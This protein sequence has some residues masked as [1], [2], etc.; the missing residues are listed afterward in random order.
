MKTDWLKCNES[1]KTLVH[2]AVFVKKDETDP[3]IYHAVDVNHINWW[4]NE[5]SEYT[6]TSG[7]VDI[8][9]EWIK[10]K[11]FN[12]IFP[13]NFKFPDNTA[14]VETVARLF[15][16]HRKDFQG[17]VTKT[18]SKEKVVE[19]LTNHGISLEVIH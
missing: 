17:M 7:T 9:A 6:I 14:T 10:W 12:E 2:G 13:N 1:S 19:E 4:D 5:E 3:G 11:E 8:T 18:K 15:Y 16:F